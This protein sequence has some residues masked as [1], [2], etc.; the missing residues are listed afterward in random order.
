MSD[1]PLGCAPF[2]VDLATGKGMPMFV[3]PEMLEETRRQMVRVWVEPFPPGYQLKGAALGWA[4][5][6]RLLEESSKTA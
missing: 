3:P 4:E 6:Q 5:W 2:R 1:C